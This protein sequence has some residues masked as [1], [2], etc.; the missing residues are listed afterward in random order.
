MEAL[1]LEDEKVVLNQDR[2]IGCGLC[3]STCPTST[4]TLVRKPESEQQKVPENVFKAALNLGRARGKFG[5]VS[6]AKMKI[7]S[8]LDRRFARK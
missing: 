3:V 2:C 5:P 4:L 1:R 7:K 6:V 8:K